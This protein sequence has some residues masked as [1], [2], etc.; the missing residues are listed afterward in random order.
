MKTLDPLELKKEIKSL[1]DQDI[2]KEIAESFG[3]SDF[4]FQHDCWWGMPPNASDAKKKA[5]RIGP[6][7]Y[8]R[9][10]YAALVL[11][12]E[13]KKKYYEWQIDGYFN[14]LHRCV[15]HKLFGHVVAHNESLARAIAE[16][17]LTAIRKEKFEENEK[18]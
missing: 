13:M 8:S 15:L 1:S 6:P 10:I 14:G 9:N 11:L 7:A 2:C 17:C 16:A 5:G 3:W 4:I 18:R 12:D